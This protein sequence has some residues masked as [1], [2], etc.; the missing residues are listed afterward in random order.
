LQ[1]LPKNCFAIAL[2]LVSPRLNEVEA[3]FCIASGDRRI[4]GVAQQSN[5]RRSMKQL[6][7][8]AAAFAATLAVSGAQAAMAP[9]P[10]SSSAANVQMAGVICGGG[11]HLHGVVCVPNGVKV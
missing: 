10:L 11:M 5:W 8:L 3:Q 1:G 6:A 9:A 4:D 2:L 7:M